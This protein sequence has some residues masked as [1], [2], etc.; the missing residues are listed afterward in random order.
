[1]IISIVGCGAV[2][3]NLAVNLAWDLKGHEKIIFNLVDFDKVENRNIRAGTQVYDYRSLNKPKTFALASMLSQIVEPKRI[4]INDQKVTKNNLKNAGGIWHSEL[5][6]D[7]VDNSETRNLLI[8]LPSP[9]FHIGFSPLMTGM[10]IWNPHFPRVTEEPTTQNDICEAAGA[11]SFIKLI[12]ALGSRT[13]LKY[14]D[15]EEKESW[16]FNGRTITYV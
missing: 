3:S 10:G 6:L 4:T 5:V 15:K 1:M 7:C 9:V 13:V 16:I 2:G 11:R 12:A 8:D 14:I